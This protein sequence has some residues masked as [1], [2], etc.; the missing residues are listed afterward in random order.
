[1]LVIVSQQFTEK[2]RDACLKSSRELVP[3]FSACAA[4]SVFRSG[5]TARPVFQWGAAAGPAKNR[6]YA[7]AEGIRIVSAFVRLADESIPTLS[8]SWRRKAA[9]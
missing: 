7:G 1:M 2:H 9:E 5:V 8:K 3:S 6:M 4:A